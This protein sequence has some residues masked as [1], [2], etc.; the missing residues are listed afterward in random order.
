M[1]LDE[2]HKKLTNDSNF[3]SDETQA[4][5]TTPTYVDAYATF[6]YD[7]LIVLVGSE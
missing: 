2:A 6:I 3:A 7:T 1:Y 4:V 5:L